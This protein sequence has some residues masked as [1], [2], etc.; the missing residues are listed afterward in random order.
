MIYNV[1]SYREPLARVDLDHAPQE[2]L[3]IWRHEVGN[4]ELASFNL[5]QEVPQ[6]VVVE[7]E[8]AHEEGVQNDAARPDV[9]LPAVVLLAL[10][11]QVRCGQMPLSKENSLT[12]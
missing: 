10:K 4:V 5:F 1:V 7:G 12:L 9:S 3:T 6:V 2:V 11:I 8:R